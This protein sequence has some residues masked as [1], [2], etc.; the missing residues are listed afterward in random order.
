M[1]TNFQLLL[2]LPV[3]TRQ[4]ET[5]DNQ[6]YVCVCRLLVREVFGK[7]GLG[8]LKEFKSLDW[9]SKGGNYNILT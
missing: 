5:T 6:K 8:V 1:Q 9:P 4:V 7:G 3:K 2:I